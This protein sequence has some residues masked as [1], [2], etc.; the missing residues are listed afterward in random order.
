MLSNNENLGIKRFIESRE[1]RIQN[2]QPLLY[3]N[4]YQITA[5]KS[6]NDII[7]KIIIQAIKIEKDKILLYKNHFNKFTY[8]GQ[9]K[10]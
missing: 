9:V 1:Y 3:N 2:I 8:I 6:K 10:I 7:D 5:I 4:C